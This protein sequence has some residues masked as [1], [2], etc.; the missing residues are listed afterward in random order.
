[1]N[2]LDPAILARVHAIELTARRIIDGMMAGSHA[3]PRHGFAVEFAHHREYVPGDDIKHLDWKVFARSER[4]YLK[5]YELE[6]NLT[7]W[8]IVDGSGS[9]GY[10]SGEVSKYDFSCIMAATLAHIVLREGDRAGVIVADSKPQRFLRSSGAGSQLHEIIRQLALGPTKQPSQIGLA[11]TELAGRLSRRSVVFIFSDFFDDVTELLQGLRRLRFD[12]HELIAVTVLDPTEE[13]F[14]FASATMF[15]GLEIPDYL[16]T[17]P[18]SL[19]QAYLEELTAHRERF[20]R[21]C[22]ELGVD[23]FDVRTDADPGLTLARFL[24][25]R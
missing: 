15:K 21:G 2:Y 4:Y 16:L 5:Q 1:M 13:D 6:T 22:R 7:C 20:R 23:L 8:L 17:D 18:R 25:E 3:S 14:P 19:R 12:R 11:L 9:M 24:A 10:A